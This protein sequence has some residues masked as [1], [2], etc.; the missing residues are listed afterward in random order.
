MKT[1]AIRSLHVSVRFVAVAVC[2]LVSLPLLPSPADGQLGGIR[3]GPPR[4]VCD[5]IRRLERGGLF[6]EV[7][8]DGEEPRYIPMGDGRTDPVLLEAGGD[9]QLGLTLGEGSIAR[10]PAR[11]R[12]EDRSFLALSAYGPGEHAFPLE[13]EYSWNAYERIQISTHNPGRRSLYLRLSECYEGGS[14][15]LYAPSE[16]RIS[17]VVQPPSDDTR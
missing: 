12:I 3:I 9:Y 14:R 10:I 13:R 5:Q 11:Y 1:N 15:H 4:P 6:V 7:A 17:L 2:L 8:R 16:T